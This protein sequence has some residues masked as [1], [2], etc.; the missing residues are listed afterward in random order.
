MD[1]WDQV[2]KNTLSDNENTSFLNYNEYYLKN[3]SINY[4][5]FNFKENLIMYKIT[6]LHSPPFNNPVVEKTKLIKKDIFYKNT[7]TL[8]KCTKTLDR[9]YSIF[10]IDKYQNIRKFNINNELNN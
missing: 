4:I 5:L 3:I 6:G 2:N 1:N 8:I 7:F 9:K 10:F